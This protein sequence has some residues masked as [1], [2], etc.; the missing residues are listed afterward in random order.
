MF[1]DTV[2]MRDAIVRK[3][4][5]FDLIFENGVSIMIGARLFG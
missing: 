2:D 1:A 3:F 5:T 4:E